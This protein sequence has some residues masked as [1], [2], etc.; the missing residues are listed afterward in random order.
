M[1]AQGTPLH[2]ASEVLGHSSIPVT[3]DV[4]AQVFEGQKRDAADAMAALR[5]TGGYIAGCLVGGRSAAAS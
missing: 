5:D 3:A 4:Y 2:V 1:L